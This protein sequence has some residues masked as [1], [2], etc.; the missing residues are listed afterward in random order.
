MRPPPDLAARRLRRLAVIGLVL[1]AALAVWWTRASRHVVSSGDI[2]DDDS[3]DG[4]RGWRRWLGGGSGAPPLVRWRL[5]GRVV[6]GSDHPVPGAAVHLA[7]PARVVTSGSDGSF[8]F[9]GLVAGAYDVD[10][11]LDDRV[12]GPVRAHVGQEGK[13]IVLRMYRGAR[14]EIQVVSAD[15]SKAIAGADVE[16]RVVH[17][18]EGAGTQRGKTGADG[19]VTLPGAILIGSEAWAAAPGFAPGFK[20]LDPSLQVNGMW[21]ARVALRPGAAI[22]GRVVDDRGGPVAGAVIEPVRSSGGR[23]G[24]AQ[25]TDS[26][27][28][29]VHPATAEVR[30]Q[31]IVSD[32]DGRFTIALPA[33]GWRLAATHQRYETSLSDR[34]FSDGKTSQGNVVILAKSGLSVRGVVQRA[35][36]QPEPGAQVQVRWQMSGRVEREVRADGNG[37]FRFVGLPPALL[38]FQAYASKTTSLPL[39]LDLEYPP[40]EEI[41]LPL[42]NDGVITGTVLDDGERPIADASVVYVEHSESVLMTRVQPSIETTD[43]DGRFAIHGLSPSATYTLNIKRPQDGDAAFRFAGVETQPGQDVVIH[44]PGDGTLIG[45]V[46]RAGGGSLGDVTVD[47]Q[48]SGRAPQPVGADGRFRFEGLF[49]RD[50]T[51]EVSSGSAAFRHVQA[52]VSANRDTDVGKIE[53]PAARQVSGVVHRPDGRPVMGASVTLTIADDEQPVLVGTD[54]DGNFA[55]NVPADRAITVLADDRRLGRSDTVTL[56]AA[57]AP[58]TIVLTF[59]ASGSVEG[60]LQTGGKPAT[61]VGVIVIA[62]Q[63]DAVRSGLSDESGYYRVDG[64]AAGAYTVQLA[65]GDPRAARVDAQH[66]KIAAGEKSFANFEVPAK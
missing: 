2:G 39:H 13:Q 54:A 30:R 14:L 62:D 58:R 25:E 59:P 49:A 1:A 46:V 65:A 29:K 22:S 33:G 20:S 12:G 16:V 64:L 50:Y 38:S 11:R 36:G 8:A 9:D 31:G 61:H 10:A 24:R 23:G 45:R 5:E 17:M 60:T 57:E 3:A 32:G 40:Q 48:N 52:T 34:L 42:V 44:V 43:G 15:D 21:R 7:I 55:A 6:D 63:G 18:H 47:V 51:V 66:V 53:L 56:P 26:R 27:L 37:H 28:G 19:K 41:K 4:A 35:D